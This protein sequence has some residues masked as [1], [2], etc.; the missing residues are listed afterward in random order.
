MY[1]KILAAVASAVVAVSVVSSSTFTATAN[2]TGDL[3]RKFTGGISLVLSRSDNALLNFGGAVTDRIVGAPT[4]TTRS[5]YDTF[6][7]S[8]SLIDDI[9]S[10]YNMIPYITK[11][12]QTGSPTSLVVPKQIDFTGALCLENASTNY[13]EMFQIRVCWNGW[14]YQTGFY[15]DCAITFSRLDSNGIS[16]TAVVYL[17]PVTEPSFT[18]DYAA[19]GGF[20]FVARMYLQGNWT[21]TGIQFKNASTNNLAYTGATRPT[22]DYWY[23]FNT[24]GDIGNAYGKP[25]YITDC[26]TNSGLWANFLKSR[27][28]QIDSTNL[29]MPIIFG[30][31]LADSLIDANFDLGG[32]SFN[33]DLGGF[34]W[35]LS[36]YGDTITETICDTMQQA[37]ENFYSDI[38]AYGELWSNK[39][40]NYYQ[41][42]DYQENPPTTQTGGTLPAEWLATYPTITTAFYVE[43]YTQTYPFV[44]VPPVPSSAF[45]LGDV[46]NRSGLVPVALALGVLSLAV[47]LV[48]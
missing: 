33:A 47:G 11:D 40:E 12:S 7:G 34:E 37:Y 48:L 9:N 24:A 41:L 20:R 38:A 28:E 32:L 44:T 13:E 45:P 36:L 8:Q 4:G 30:G 27:Q 15:P 14:R 1:K 29:N 43:P 6:V 21:V 25:Y 19:T 17:D 35:D 31:I 39:S 42:Y 2:F 18:T 22:G 46:L 23:R 10:N 16:Q 26:A 3:W 5:V